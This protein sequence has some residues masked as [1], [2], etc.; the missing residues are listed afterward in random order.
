M[1]GVL[2]WKTYEEI[3]S[4]E[5]SP[6]ETLDKSTKGSRRY[7]PISKGIPEKITRET[8]SEIPGET[9][10]GGKNPGDAP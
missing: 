3:F 9:P 6:R 8:Q 1:G 10:F 2:G 7:V 5:E 4:F